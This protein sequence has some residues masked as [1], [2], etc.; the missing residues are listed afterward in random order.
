MIT[1]IKNF[2][3]KDRFIIIIYRT[4]SRFI[5]TSYNP[6]TILFVPVNFHVYQTLSPVFKLFRFSP[7]LR[8]SLESSLIGSLPTP[9]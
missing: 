7:E 4:M 3:R 6:S 9:S 8:R 5:N 1:T 2:S